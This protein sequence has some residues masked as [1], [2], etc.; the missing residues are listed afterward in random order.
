MGVVLD[1]Y[2]EH[3]ARS[4]ARRLAAIRHAERLVMLGLLTR[5]Q[6]AFVMQRDLRNRSWRALRD[7]NIQETLG[8]TEKQKQEIEHVAAMARSNQGKEG[9]AAVNQQYLSGLEGVLTASQRTAWSRLTAK[10]SLPAQPP[11]LPALA[12]ADAADVTSEEVSPIFHALAEKQDDLKLAADQ[13][14]MLGE[15]QTL[16]RKGLLWISHAGGCR[17]QETRAA[18]IKHAEQVAL[19]GI[20]TERQASRV[21]AEIEGH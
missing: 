16:T 3:V 9:L 4:N 21:Q 19:L 15:L 1:L 13:N 7:A 17:E 8:M 6:A 2:R 5:P 12:A 18:F 14:E 20:L 11:D 10:P